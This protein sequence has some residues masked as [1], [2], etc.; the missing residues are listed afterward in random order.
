MTPGRRFALFFSAYFFTN[1]LTLA[2]WP[3]WLQDRGL[4]AAAIGTLLF[5]S[6]WIKVGG[7]L[8]SGDFADRS[9]RPLSV[10]IVL[11]VVGVLAMALFAVPGKFWWLLALTLAWGSMWPSILPIADGQAM[12]ASTRGAFDYGRVRLWGSVT[13][14]AATIGGGYLLQWYGSDAIHL[15]VLAAAVVTAALVPLLPLHG[16]V[17]R[18]GGLGRGAMLE[19]LR[20][21]PFLLFLVAGG[22]AQVS[23]AVYY[24]FGTLDFRA[25]GLDDGAIGLLWAIG[26][27]AEIALFALGRQLATG[28]GVVR[29]F[30][31]AG[32][33]AVLRWAV[34]PF[35]DD[36][37]PLLAVQSLHALT[38]GAAHLGALLF[39]Q[40]R[41]P[42][43][44]ISSAQALYAA[45]PIGLGMGLAMMAAGLLY[46]S[47][48]GWAYLAMVGLGMLSLLA[49]AALARV[50]RGEAMAS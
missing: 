40:S 8:L 35:I 20:D 46:E 50:W 2:F 15:A 28:I 7:T 24:A 44:A 42:I 14:I 26:V 19:L 34:T 27:V 30:A 22:A 29:L 5:A 41:V 48:A 13:F 45:L 31:I 4:D 17:A 32:L 6:Q 36:F 9:G 47:V 33:G 10:V 11:A 25:K 3:V 1:A 37:L 39:I 43:R 38:F 16:F 23:H 49:T 12:Q 18:Q 21:R